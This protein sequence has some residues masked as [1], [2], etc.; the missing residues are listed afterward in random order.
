MQKPQRSKIDQRWRILP[1]AR[2]HRIFKGR[3]FL[4]IRRSLEKPAGLFSGLRL[5]LWRKPQV[6]SHYVPS[7]LHNIHT[8]R[9]PD[10]FVPSFRWI[11]RKFV[12]IG[13]TLSLRCVTIWLHFNQEV[14]HV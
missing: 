7:V 5:F 12:K 3:E 8:S 13:L 11:P 6:F 14:L 10:H 1:P 9:T 2:R 4:E